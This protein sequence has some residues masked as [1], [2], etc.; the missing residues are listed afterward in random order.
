MECHVVA[1]VHIK[2]ITPR[3]S[4]LCVIVRAE[5]F[6]LRSIGEIIFEIRCVPS[7]IEPSARFEHNLFEILHRAT[8]QMWDG[9]GH[10]GNFAKWVF[11]RDV[12][13]DGDD[14]VCFTY[15]LPPKLMGG[16]LRRGA[17][18]DTPNEFF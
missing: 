14:C 13:Q 10:D 17:T 18:L 5:K 7:I 15:M 2:P 1:L 9:F 4:Q 16:E 12:N 8:F 3:A 11:R 6:D